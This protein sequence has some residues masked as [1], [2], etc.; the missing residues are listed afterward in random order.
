MIKNIDNKNFKF[1]VAGGG[2]AGW[3]SALILKR[4]YPDTNVTLIESSAIDILGAGEGT[5]PNFIYTLDAINIPLSEIVKNCS[6]TFKN[7]IKFTNWNGDGTHYFHGFGN[8]KDLDYNF[9]TTMDYSGAPMLVLEQIMTGKNLNN[10]DFSAIAA[11]QNVAKYMTNS[12]I[13]N[14][15][16][17]PILHFTRLG[18][19]ALHFNAVQ[20]AQY[21]K[22]VGKQRG[23]N[24]IDGVIEKINT[25][26]EGYITSLACEGG[27]VINGDFVFDCTGFRRLIIGNFYKSKWKSYKDKLPVNRALPFF[28][29]LN[30]DTDVIPPYTEAIAAKNGWMWKIPTHD[31]YGCGYVFDSRMTS[32]EDAKKEI[33]ALTGIDTEIP[34]SFSFEP[35]VYEQPWIKN[36]VA[37]GLASGF[38]EPLEATSIW[39]S[40]SSMTHFLYNVIGC[41]ERNQKTIDNYNRQMNHIT[42]NILT[43]LQFHYITPRNDTSF[44]KDFSVNNKIDDVILSLIDKDK[45]VSIIADPVNINYSYFTKDSWYHVGAGTKFFNAELA[46][47]SFNGYNCGTKKSYYSAARAKYISNTTLTATGLINHRALL[48]YLKQNPF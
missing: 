10:V 39:V 46:Q 47:K 14:K 32:D 22:K 33:D 6:G 3:L 34:R 7:G 8:V 2:T 17:N 36:C 12:S 19:S 15:L 1:V 25:D 48:Q 45:D 40:T 44:W 5:V 4:F 11:S 24:V 27:R 35:G 29:P 42:D 20:L 26:E 21:F 38:V 16:D 30:L 43:F 9:Q 28:M 37:V 23:I 41:T 31:R 13:A 18:E